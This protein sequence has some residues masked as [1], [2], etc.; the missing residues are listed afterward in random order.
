M[1]SILSW[2]VP[3]GFVLA[4]SVAL[5]MGFG[6][7]GALEK[8]GGG[9]PWVVFGAVVL[10]GGFFHRSRVVLIA[11]GLGG[12]HLV[13]SQGAGGFTGFFL[14]GGLLALSV[15]FLVLSQDRGVFST[16]GLF[17][18]AVLFVGFSFGWLL[19]VVAPEDIASFLALMPLPAGVTVW[20]G[21][22]QPVFLAFA[23]SL[24]SALTVSVLRDG[25]VE[26]AGFWSLLMVALALYFSTDPGS[27]GVF[28][29][30]AALTMG[31]SVVETSHAMAYKDDLTGL[32]ARRALM[33]ELDGIGGTYSAAMVD[34][35]HFKKFNDRYGHDV[36]DQ[37]LRMVAARL[38][39]APGGGRAYRYGGEEFTLLFPGKALQEALPHLKEARRSVEDAVFT[40]RSW[41]RPRKKPVDP[42]AWRGTGKQK[43]KRL[44]VTVSIGVAD[45][46][47][48]D[49]SPE[50]V[51]RRADQALYRAKKAGRNRVA[52]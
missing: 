48:N 33:R 31:L 42:G 23:F 27:V 25:P 45:S 46:A 13:F 38:A 50:A 6:P 3:G 4:L 24:P 43:P 28:L 39:K 19:I 47:G 29:M 18:L 1:K 37:V 40:L 14:A 30:G 32:P 51:L 12:L 34:V 41:R 20:S 7:E 16:A 2:L 22:P 49:P 8:V 15:G 11:L 36:G 9:Y 21:L 5:A 52:K 44:S 26:R 17:Q 10:L 35:D